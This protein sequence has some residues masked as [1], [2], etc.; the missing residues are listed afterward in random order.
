MSKIVSLSEAASIAIHAMILIAR[1]GEKMNVLEIAEK[2]GSSK[3]HIAK[4][5]QRL[6]KDGFLTSGRGPMGGFAINKDLN[7]ITLLQIYECI[8]GEIKIQRCFQE[9]QICP[10]DLC[11]MNNITQTMTQTMKDYLHKQTLQNYI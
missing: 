9:K 8:E 5:M 2:T 11:F 6:V 3:H 1:S 4:V 7:D 10:F